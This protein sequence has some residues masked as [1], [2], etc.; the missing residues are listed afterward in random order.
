MKKVIGTILIL[1]GIFVI[2]Y[3]LFQ[4]YNAQK[5]QRDMLNAYLEENKV[6]ADDSDL[7]SLNDNFRWADNEDNQDELNLGVDE[8]GL[9]INEYNG[10]E[11][12][13]NLDEAGRIKQ[14]PKAIGILK[15]D[16]I[17]LFLPI[18]EGVDLATLKFALGHMPKTAGI[19]EVGN[20]VIAGHRSYSTGVFF[21][22]L[23]Q[24]EI[25]DS[26]EATSNGV[27]YKYKVYEILTVEPDDTSVLRG[28]KTN[29]VMTLITCTPAVKATHRLIIHA[30]MED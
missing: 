1:A 2:L 13:E 18:A 17:D 24:L 5:Q 28:S 6:V 22:S 3:P 16:K 29:K 7:D 19:G 14:K 10:E 20:C 30:V 15:I 21:N 23:D 25:G 27:D 4:R 12:E 8:A 11:V 26:I 9:I